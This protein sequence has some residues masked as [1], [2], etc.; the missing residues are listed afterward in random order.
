MRFKQT[1]GYSAV[2]KS[3]YEGYLAKEFKVRI[4]Y[5][6][7]GLYL[8]SVGDSSDK[9]KGI[10]KFGPKAF[11]KLLIKLDENENINWVECGDYEKMREVIEK[12]RKYLDDRQFEELQSS[13]NLVAN[14]ELNC[15]LPE[16]IEKSTEDKRRDAYSELNMFSLIS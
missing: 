1:V 7:I 6:A 5:N 2:A 4:P 13:F 12:C 9:I 11:E 15:E 14:V 3:N 8:A 16:P 10:T